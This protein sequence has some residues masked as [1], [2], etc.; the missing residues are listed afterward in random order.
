MAWHILVLLYLLWPEKSLHPMLENTRQ[1]EIPGV[2]GSGVENTE[3]THEER[4]VGV[5]WMSDL[6]IPMIQDVW[7][8]NFANG[9][10][11]RG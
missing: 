3:E 5:R 2:V 6:W 9:S 1:H 10:D 7:N 8:A 11:G 4:T